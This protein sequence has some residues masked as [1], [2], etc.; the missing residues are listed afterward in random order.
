ML[1]AE[2]DTTTLRITTGPTPTHRDPVTGNAESGI[3]IL[4]EG[5]QVR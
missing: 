3:K 2:I 4:P 5:A 1:D